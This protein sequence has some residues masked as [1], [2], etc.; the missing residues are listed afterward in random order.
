MAKLLSPEMLEAV[1]S[2]MLRVETDVLLKLNTG[3][4]GKKSELREFLSDLASTT[5]R[6]IV[7]EEKLQHPSAGPLT[8]QV[9]ARTKNSEIYFSGIPGGH[10]FNSLI[11]AILQV[12]PLLSKFT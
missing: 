12:F 9:K 2:Y 3:D 1:R 5:T 10:E 11:L 6:L 8:F 7:E 4:H